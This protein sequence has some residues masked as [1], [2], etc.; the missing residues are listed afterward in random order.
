MSSSTLKSKAGQ[1]APRTFAKGS[2]MDDKELMKQAE[3]EVAETKFFMPRWYIKTY[4]YCQGPFIALAFLSLC[5]FFAFNS[6]YF[7]FTGG[8]CFF[9]YIGNISAYEYFKEESKRVFERLKNERSNNNG[10]KNNR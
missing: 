5:L 7:L 4:P 3:T 1:I 8:I 9:M 6:S 2:E 10:G